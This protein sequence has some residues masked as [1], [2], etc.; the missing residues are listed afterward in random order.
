MRVEFSHKGWFGVCPVLL[1]DIDGDAPVVHPRHVLL[2]P[3][4]WLSEAIFAAVFLLAAAVRPQW[5]PAW[6]LHVTG[7]LPRPLVR[8]FPDAAEQP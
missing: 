1:A 5:E 8:E 2:A 4:F 6:P 3:L 7:E